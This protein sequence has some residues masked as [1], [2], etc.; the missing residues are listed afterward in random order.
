MREK[1]AAVTSLP[2]GRKLLAYSHSL[3]FTKI[4]VSGSWC[5]SHLS[6]FSSWTKLFSLWV[7]SAKIVGQSKSSFQTTGRSRLSQMSDDE[8]DCSVA[9]MCSVRVILTVGRTNRNKQMSHLLGHP[10]PGIQVS[11][12]SNPIQLHRFHLYKCLR[13]FFFSWPIGSARVR[14]G[15]KWKKTVVFKSY[16]SPIKNETQKQ[17][18]EGWCEDSWITCQSRC[19]T[20]LK[21]WPPPS[22]ARMAWSSANIS[23]F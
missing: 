22:D 6:V 13:S 11:S 8:C 18:G 5:Y 4:D 20:I 21:T 2:K 14:L 10:H 12:L 3:C 1:L 19:S 23:S 7:P 17:G 16:F 15:C 9:H